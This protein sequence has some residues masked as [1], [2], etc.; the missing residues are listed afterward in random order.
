MILWCNTNWA[1]DSDRIKIHEDSELNITETITGLNNIS[2]KK[3][4]DT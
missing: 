2:N 3:F 4:L 1:E